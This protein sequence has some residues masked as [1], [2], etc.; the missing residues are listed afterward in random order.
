MGLGRRGA[1]VSYFMLG[2][3]WVN[4]AF[5]EFVINLGFDQGCERDVHAVAH[6]LSRLQ[7]GR[8]QKL[9]ARHRRGARGAGVVPDLGRWEVN[10]FPIL[11][12]LTL[13]PLIGGI[14]VV[15]VQ[16]KQLARRFA[17]GFS[18]LIARVGVG[19]VE[20]F[21]CCERRSAIRR[22]ARLDSD[23]RRAVFRRRGWPRAVDGDAHGHRGADGVAGVGW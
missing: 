18:F 15:G 6:C 10:G 5:D 19:L 17:L 8:V 12:I 14:I 1:L 21:R 2:L 11:T 16:D 3:A 9:S 22:E 13:L 23:A 4:R 7:D 20:I